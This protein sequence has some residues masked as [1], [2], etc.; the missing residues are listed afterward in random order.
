MRHM[1]RISKLTIK[2]M[3]D[4]DPD[5]SYLGEYSNGPTSDYSIDREHDIECPAQTYNKPTELLNQLERIIQYL[6]IERTAEASKPESTLWES[7]DEAQGLIAEGQE[8]LLQCTCEYHGDRERNELR[9][10]NPC[11]QNYTELEHSEIVKYCLQ[12]YAR[13]QSLNRGDW[14]FI[15]VRAEAAI[16][17]D[18]VV[19]NISSGGL[20]G[21]ESDSDQ[22]Y[23]TE[24]ESEQLSELREQLYTLG[25]SKRAVS[26][27][28]K[29]AV[30]EEL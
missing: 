23:F 20:W 5:T 30:G 25:F 24:I 3:P 13:M 19:Q 8:E 21:V 15:G 18:G 16:V 9:Y 17:V 10:F 7:L 26:A 11:H 28:V 1:K 12:D 6:E 29:N 27:A 22:A 14:C 2:R 4:R